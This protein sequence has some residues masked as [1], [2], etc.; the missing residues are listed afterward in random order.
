MAIEH[1]GLPRSGRVRALVRRAGVMIAPAVMILLWLSASALPSAAASHDQYYTIFREDK[2]YGA[3]A[4]SCSEL[5][6]RLAGPVSAQS[7]PWE[8]AVLLALCGDRTDGCWLAEA[9]DQTPSSN[10]P[11]SNTSSG[12]SGALQRPQPLHS[13]DG[14]IWEWCP[15]VTVCGRG[16][17]SGGGGG[18]TGGAGSDADDKTD[19]NDGCSDLQAEDGNT[20]EAIPCNGGAAQLV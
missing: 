5:G 11:S 20:L 9:S 4:A 3:A 14:R 13:P 1:S 10:T 17:G 12:S 8:V 19:D 6:G 7:D 16:R 15:Y 18:G 2:E